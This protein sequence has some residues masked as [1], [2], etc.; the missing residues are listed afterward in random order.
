MFAKLAEGGTQSFVG[1]RG[2]V[3]HSQQNRDNAGARTAY[4]GCRPRYVGLPVAAALANAV[5]AK[6][7]AEPMTIPKSPLYW[8]L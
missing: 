5:A 4:R 8:C 7:A 6:S 2:S 3:A 1:L